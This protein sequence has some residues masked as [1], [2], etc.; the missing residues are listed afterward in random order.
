MSATYVLQKAMRGALL[1]HEPLTAIIGT[2]IFDAVPQATAPPY[3]VFDRIETRDWSTKDRRG[4]EHVVTLHVWSA[5]EGKAEA[6]EIIAQLDAAL[7][8]Q[9]L[10]LDGHHLVSL[11]SVF[12]TALR[13]PDGR[14]HH[15][16]LRL[17]ATTEE[18]DT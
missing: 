2:K 10:V 14:F 11:S 8:N 6:Y 1:A 16:I 4:F 18:T 9:A 12:W 13:T 3:V 7:D 15:G 17:R 5:H